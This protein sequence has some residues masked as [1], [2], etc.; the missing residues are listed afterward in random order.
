MRSKVSF[1]MSVDIVS[2]SH[3]LVDVFGIIDDR[4]CIEKQVFW[5]QEKIIII[6]TNSTRRQ[7]G[8]VW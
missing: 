4:F 6:F 2:S 3:I 7:I 5:C 1:L 8:K